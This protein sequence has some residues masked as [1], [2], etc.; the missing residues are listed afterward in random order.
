MSCRSVEDFLCSCGLADLDRIRDSL[1]YPHI[2]NCTHCQ[3]EY[4]QTRGYLELMQSVKEPIWNAEKEQRLLAPWKTTTQKSDREKLNFYRGFAL[5]CLLS[6]SLGLGYFLFQHEHRAHDNPATS[7]WQGVDQTNVSIVIEVPSP[8][9]QAELSLQFPKGLRWQ[10]LEKMPTV[11][12]RVDL[13]AGMNILDI[14]VAFSM[15]MIKD[16]RQNILVGI[17]Y[18]ENSRNF[19]L[20]VRVSSHLETDSVL[21]PQNAISL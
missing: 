6:W 1:L 5:A 13:A 12:W 11:A 16:K 14:P 9:Q 15:D 21:A 4:L 20:P 17:Q 2:K 18:Q 8:M 7:H 3:A 10:G 19:S